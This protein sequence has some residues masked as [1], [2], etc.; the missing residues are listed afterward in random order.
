M[1][2]G[3]LTNFTVDNVSGYATGTL[4]ADSSPSACSIFMG[5]KPRVVRCTQISGTVG[6]GAVTTANSSMTAGY[7][8]QQVAAG[9]STIPTSNGYTFL[10]GTEASRLLLLLVAP[11]RLALVSRSGPLF[12]LLPCCHRFEIGAS[13]NTGSV[14][15]S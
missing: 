15:D 7:M 12:R 4:T 13:S 1:A 10:D 8:T 2:V 5:F 9:T 14:H 3:V 6:N 11:C